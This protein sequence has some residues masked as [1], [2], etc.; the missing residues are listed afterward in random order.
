[1]RLQRYVD[2]VTGQPDDVIEKKARRMQFLSWFWLCLLVLM[3]V[4]FV[5]GV[6]STRRFVWNELLAKTMPFITM[7]AITA[8]VRDTL[9]LILLMKKRNSQP[10]TGG[11]GKPAPQS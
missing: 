7:A 8:S 1:M 6:V 4:E 10:T 2:R 9:L 3:T 5:A 11:D